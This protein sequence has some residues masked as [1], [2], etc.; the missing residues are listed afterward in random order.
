MKPSGALHTNCNKQSLLRIIACLPLKF[1]VPVFLF[2]LF[3]CSWQAANAQEDRVEVIHS[4]L[5]QLSASVPGLNQK[6]QLSVTGV[7]VKEFLRALAQA[8]KLNINI[9]PKLNFK[10][11]TNF[12]NETPLNILTFLA[13]EY[14][15]DISFL[16]TIMTVSP[17]EGQGRLSKEI[18]A[19]YS[20]GTDQLSLELSNDSLP[21]VAKKISQ[22]SG[23]NIIVPSALFGKKVNGF[24]TEAPF[25]TVL[26]QLAYSNNI[27][28]VKTS[29]NVFVFQA[30]R[31]GE[32]VF[33]NPEKKTSVRKTFKQLSGEGSVSL[34]SRNVNGQKLI[35]VDAINASI[36]DLIRAASQELS[37]SFF[38]YSD[39]KGTISTTVSN[40]TFDNFLSSLLQGTDYT[41]KLENGVYLIGDRRLEGLR[42]NRVIQLQNRSVDT[43]QAMIPNEWKKGIEIREFREQNTLLLSGS[44][45]QIEEIEAFIKQLD[46]LVPLVLI[47]VNLVD[48]RKVRS[49]KT[50]IKA[51]TSDSVKTGGTVLPGIDYT[52]GA[53][54]INDFLARLGNI[55]SVNLGRVTPNFYVGLSALEENN[56]VEVR[57]VPK[58]STLNGHSATLSIGSRRYYLIRRQNV[59]PTLGSTQNIFTDEYV[60]VDAN[61]AINI[62]PIV[63][64]DDQVTLNIKVDI[65][66]FIG[67]P[68][69]NAPP[70]T[71]NSKFESI[72]RARN[73]DMIVLGGLERAEK[74]DGSSGVPVLSRIPVLKWIFSSKE[75]LNSKVVTIVFIKPTIMY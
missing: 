5:V 38:L 30:L 64:G 14:N 4:R 26:E 21:D 29:E 15:L 24:F 49:V 40:I 34:S 9:D 75:K 71:S 35:T 48:I 53:R 50:G 33:I 27:G 46:Q 61:L 60:P 51:G 20:S 44:R 22:I 7:P 3:S 55:S 36:A 70:P 45:P 19:A 68:S 25:E 58:L 72:I 2:I 69:N 28:I 10:I 1:C 8:N 17:I 52:L 56:N 37:K 31:E 62:K 6:I 13:K 42:T 32:E 16:G 39:I 59:F 66:D 67:I 43:I 74:S 12:N 65:S 73:E 23:K 41:Y 63:S 54:A 18:K 57:S 11:Y 47:E